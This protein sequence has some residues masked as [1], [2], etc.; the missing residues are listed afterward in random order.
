MQYAFIYL[1]LMMLS[2]SSVGALA[3]IAY[4]LSERRATLLE[5][6]VHGLVAPAAMLSIAAWFMDPSP[7]PL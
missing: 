7:F 3:L 2:V 6:A 5:G 4:M 1:A